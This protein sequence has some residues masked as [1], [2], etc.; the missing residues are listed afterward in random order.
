[1]GITRTIPNPTEYPLN[2]QNTPPHPGEW[3]GL[4]PCWSID[5]PPLLSLKSAFFFLR[6][7]IS[8]NLETEGYVQ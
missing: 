3:N 4:G 5:V 7:G 1:M 8:Q 6:K 2:P